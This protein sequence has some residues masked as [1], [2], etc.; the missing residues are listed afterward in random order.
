MVSVAR[1]QPK[2]KHL[3]LS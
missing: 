2:G 3:S 1:E